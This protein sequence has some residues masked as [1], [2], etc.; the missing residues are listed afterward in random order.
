MRAEG[1]RW[2]H[3][4]LFAAAIAAVAWGAR[5]GFSRSGGVKL[6]NS[7]TLV[8]VKTGDLFEFDVSGHR[9]VVVPEKNPQTGEH[10][11]VVAYKTENGSWRIY[12]RQLSAL[13]TIPGPHGAVVDRKTGEVRVTSESPRRGR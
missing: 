11:L 10:T 13:D 6:V 12:E 4:L 8:D 9:P 7:V 2:W 1:L 5:V 3:Y